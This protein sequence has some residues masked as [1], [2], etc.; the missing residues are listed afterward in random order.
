MNAVACARTCTQHIRDSLVDSVVRSHGTL[1]PAGLV[2][3]HGH[4]GL[5]VARSRGVLLAS[6]CSCRCGEKLSRVQSSKGE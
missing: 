6:S 1:C 2:G 5:M 3:W 4:G